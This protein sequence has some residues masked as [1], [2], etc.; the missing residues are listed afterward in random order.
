MAFVGPV[1]IATGSAAPPTMYGTPAEPSNAPFLGSTYRSPAASPVATITFEPVSPS[2]PASFTAARP[3]LPALPI[4]KTEGYVG[5]PQPKLTQSIGVSSA[6][7]GFTQPQSPIHS[8][9]ALGMT[10]RTIKSSPS[11]SV[12]FNRPISVYNA[13]FM[14]DAFLSRCRSPLGPCSPHVN[15][16]P[17]APCWLA[18]PLP[19]LNPVHTFATSPAV[20]LNVVPSSPVG[21]AM[22][23]SSPKSCAA[24][25]RANSDVHRSS[26][27]MAVSSS[28]GTVA[29]PGYNTSTLSTGPVS[30]VTTTTASTA[31]LLP[32]SPK[33]S[34]VSPTYNAAIRENSAPGAIF[35]SE[36]PSGTNTAFAGTNMVITMQRTSGSPFAPFAPRPPRVSRG[37]MMQS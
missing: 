24:A 25:V 5:I 17:S 16:P 11:M 8:V 36:R 9:G 27:G 33:L 18:P 10:A 4:A 15:A 28:F 7:L 23:L 31:P 29:S 1:T 13:P 14:S 3:V 35:R 19:N 20:T 26:G 12:I 22:S 2:V 6:Y 37:Y 30:P 32:A 34:T 21:G